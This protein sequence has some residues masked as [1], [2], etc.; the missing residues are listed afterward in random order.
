MPHRHPLDRI[1][2]APEW[3]IEAVLK[4]NGEWH[5]Y[6]DAGGVKDLNSGGNVVLLAPGLRVSRGPFSGFASFGI[7]I[8]NR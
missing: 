2:A 7:P 6:Q 4:L 3:T 8:V 5:D 1:P